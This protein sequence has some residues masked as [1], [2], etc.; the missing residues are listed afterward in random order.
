MF[1]SFTGKV[2][3]TT[4]TMIL[5]RV[6]ELPKLNT[7]TLKKKIKIMIPYHIPVDL[8]MIVSLKWMYHLN[9]S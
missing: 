8:R 1:G 3:E 9:V 2:R 6:P 4:V 7:K 5:S